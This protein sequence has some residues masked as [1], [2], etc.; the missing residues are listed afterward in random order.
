[1]KRMPFSVWN[2][3]VNRTGTTTY[4]ATHSL[5]SSHLAFT[6]LFPCIALFQPL[7]DTFERTYIHVQIFLPLFAFL[8]LP[9]LVRF[10][11]IFS[12]DSSFL[13]FPLFSAT[14]LAPCWSFYFQFTFLNISRLQTGNEIYRIVILK[15]FIYTSSCL[16][17]VFNRSVQS[18]I[19]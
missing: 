4:W 10:V 17:D 5:I 7:A 6:H 16:L 13:I 1:M 15:E 14:I 2:G 3:I 11:S 19:S 18:E 12:R 9:F 8:T